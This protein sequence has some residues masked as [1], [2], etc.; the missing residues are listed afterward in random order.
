MESAKGAKIIVYREIDFERVILHDCANVFSHVD[1]LRDN[2]VPA[3]ARCTGCGGK[4]RCKNFNSC[5]FSCT[6]RTEQ[7]ENL[8]FFD[9][10]RNAV[11]GVNKGVL[12]L[13]KN[14]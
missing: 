9:I 11:Q 14:L 1:P 12:T 13:G 3:H 10:E 7:S 4:K 2:I 6:I 5:R 8:S